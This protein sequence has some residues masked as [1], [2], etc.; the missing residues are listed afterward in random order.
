MSHND[1]K[2]YNVTPSQMLYVRVK[3]SGC[4][5]NLQYVDAEV[6]TLNITEEVQ[7]VR[8]SQIAVNHRYHEEE[9]KNTGIH[10][11]NIRLYN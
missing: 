10:N 5:S 7:E 2:L 4:Y 1:P 6:I 9:L 8:R 3:H 11:Y